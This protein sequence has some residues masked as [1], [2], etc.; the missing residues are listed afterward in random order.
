[1]ITIIATSNS[2]PGV[3]GASNGDGQRATCQSELAPHL[4]LWP[5]AGLQ[6][7]AGS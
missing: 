1:M 5:A 6:G 4:A 7:L 2:V 3:R